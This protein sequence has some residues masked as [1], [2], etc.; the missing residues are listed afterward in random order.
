MACI[1]CGKCA[2]TCPFEAIT[3]DNNLAYIDFTKCK[4]CRKCVEVCPQSTIIDLN[5]PP[6]KPKEETPVPAAK[7]TVAGEKVQTAK[8]E[9]SQTSAPAAAAQLVATTP[10]KATGVLIPE[11][12]KTVIENAEPLNELLVKE[13]QAAIELKQQTN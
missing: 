4:S 2:K 3:V 9:V 12:P 1:A 8:P 5:F 10:V 11:A 7:E 13:A 6:R